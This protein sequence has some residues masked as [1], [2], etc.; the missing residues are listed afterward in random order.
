MIRSCCAEH[1]TAD[2]D[3]GAHETIAFTIGHCERCG[4]ALVHARTPY[5]PA[6]GTVHAI[7]AEKHAQLLEGNEV[8]LDIFRRRFLEER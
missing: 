4:R 7:S 3:G 8:D 6:A 5:G 1:F 2:R